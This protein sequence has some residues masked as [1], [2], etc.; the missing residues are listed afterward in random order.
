[1]LGDWD[2]AGIKIKRDMMKCYRTRLRTMRH[3]G[4]AGTIAI[5]CKHYCHLGPEGMAM[6]CDK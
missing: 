1:M 4:E 3:E 2:R 5:F 6:N